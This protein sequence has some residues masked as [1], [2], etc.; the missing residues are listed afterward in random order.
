MYLYKV[1]VCVCNIYIYIYHDASVLMK[2]RS[3]P[4]IRLEKL[5]GLRLAQIF[6][7]LVI[8]WAYHKLKGL[9]SVYLQNCIE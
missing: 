5:F 4:K 6:W 8:T 3:F 7:G 9:I 2:L 1:Y